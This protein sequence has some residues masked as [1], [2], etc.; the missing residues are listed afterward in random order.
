MFLRHFLMMAAAAALPAFFSAGA[1]QKPVDVPEALKVTEFVLSNGCKVYV[2]ED[3]SQPSVYG[4][5]VVKAGSNDCPD[6]GIAHYFEHMMFK[7][8]SRI[9]T[10]DYAA[11][12]VYLDSIAVAYDR[13]ALTAGETTII[14]TTTGSDITNQGQIVVYVVN[15]GVGLIDDQIDQSEAE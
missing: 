5:V 14:A 9:G 6:T 11:E 12:K 1:V 3:H 2:N 15:M 8:T 13:L 10:T 7:G 4:A